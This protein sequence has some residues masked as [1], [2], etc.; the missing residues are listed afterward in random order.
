MEEVQ[1]LYIMK[2][3]DGYVTPRR[4]NLAIFNTKVKI[5]YH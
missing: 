3:I 1:E 4:Y 5:Y 2:N